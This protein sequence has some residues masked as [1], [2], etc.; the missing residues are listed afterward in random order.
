MASVMPSVNITNR[1][2]ISSGSVTSSSSSANFLA[3][4]ELQ[5]EHHAAGGEQPGLS[6]P[7]ACRQVDER[8]VPGSGVGHRPR[9]EIED[10][11]GHRDEAAAVQVRGDDRLAAI[12]SARGDMWIV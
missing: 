10:R 1:S 12:I 5:T 8:R 11:V 9:F 2:P 3:V 4:V 7:S 6:A